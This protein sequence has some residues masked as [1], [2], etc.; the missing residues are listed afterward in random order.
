MTSAT[1]LLIKK[2]QAQLQEKLPAGHDSRPTY[3]RFFMAGSMA[4]SKFDDSI[5]Q[6]LQVVSDEAK[7]TPNA[8]INAVVLFLGPDII[9]R[10][11]F[12]QLF[13]QRMVGLCQLE[14][15]STPVDVKSFSTGSVMPIGGKQFY[16]TGIHP[17]HRLKALRFPF[18]ALVFDTEPWIAQHTSR[19]E[20]IYH[21]CMS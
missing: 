12:D 9:T 13:V 4:E 15:S 17:A 18:P 19:M 16:V 6:F 11:V 7:S 5:R 20:D 3:H 10:D 1:N 21:Q 2:I 8:H 14:Q